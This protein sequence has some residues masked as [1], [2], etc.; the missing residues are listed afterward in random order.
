M[1]TTSNVYV[2]QKFDYFVP[3]G[4]FNDIKR[5]IKS[6]MFYPLY[7]TG[8]SGNGKTMFIE[9]ACAQTKRELIRVNITSESDEDSL[10]GGFR[11]KD[12]NTVWHDGPV[13]EAL[14]HG[15]VLLL[16]EVDLATNKIMCLQPILEGKGIFLKRCKKHVNPAPGFTVIATANTK[17]NGSDDGRYI[18]TNVLN[19]AFLDR[20]PLTIEQNYP[21]EPTELRILKKMAEKIEIDDENFLVTLVK[22]ANTNRQLFEK[23]SHEEVISTRRLIHILVAYK[24][25]NNKMKAVESCLTLYSNTNAQALV[26]L[27]AK[28]DAFVNGE[29]DEDPT[30]GSSDSSDDD[31]SVEEDDS[32]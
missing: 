29:T 6:K 17:G 1:T 2:P 18:G 22:W 7:L 24:I 32:I 3:F 23:D 15:A 4:P 19:Q 8:L 25:F 26:E 16:D 12:G 28:H 21:S 31:D 11:L 30:Q 13:V 9:Q 14:T 20:F 5:I 27:Y 10:L